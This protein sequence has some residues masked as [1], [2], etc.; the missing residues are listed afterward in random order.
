MLDDMTP[1]MHDLHVFNEDA[2]R[3]I[4]DKDYHGATLDFEFK[5]ILDQIKISFWFHDQ[6]W[7]TTSLPTEMTKCGRNEL[8]ARLAD[9]KA[10]LITLPH[11]AEA[12]EHVLLR[13]YARVKERIAASRLPDI[14]K[15]EAEALMTKMTTNI[16][17]HQPAVAPTVLVD[18]GYV[19][20]DAIPAE[21]QTEDDVEKLATQGP[22]D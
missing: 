10:W 6:T 4:S 3:I 20:N 18:P 5:P 1:S 17:T 7:G 13:D 9:I 8:R 15:A 11:E 12:R 22:A 2:R 14:V 16:I 19:F 21:T